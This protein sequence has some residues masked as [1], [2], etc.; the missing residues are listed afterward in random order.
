MD[1]GFFCLTWALGQ[2][3]SHSLQIKV[4]YEVDLSLRL[5]SHWNAL[6][7]V[8]LMG[9][10]CSKELF[11]QDCTGSGCQ[12]KVQGRREFGH[13]FPLLLHTRQSNSGSQTHQQNSQAFEHVCL[14]S[15]KHR[16]PGYV[17]FS[18]VKELFSSQIYLSL[19]SRANFMEI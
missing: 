10:P 12:H 9:A 11:M 2:D 7:T 6:E 3:W 4:R 18:G 19:S 14:C 5:K 17:S 13:S 1:T 15:Q 16:A 8:L